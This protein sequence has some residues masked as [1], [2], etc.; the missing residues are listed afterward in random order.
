MR[1]FCI[2]SSMPPLPRRES[3][4]RVREMPLQGG[5]RRIYRRH[6]RLLAAVVR[7]RAG[8]PKSCGYCRRLECSASGCMRCTTGGAAR[9]AFQAGQ[10]A[11]ARSRRSPQSA[12]FLN[13]DTHDLS[14]WACS[15][16]H[17]ASVGDRDARSDVVYS[18]ARRSAWTSPY[19]GL[20]LPPSH[21]FKERDQLPL[22]RPKACMAFI[23]AIGRWALT[24]LVIIASSEAVSSGCPGN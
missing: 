12:D 23:R 19:S 2:R 22:R 6:F 3:L 1:R 15:L 8:R 13:T 9:G 5:R 24:G 21:G 4:D 14:R 7:S 17:S 18:L 16:G 20:S 11:P 10:S